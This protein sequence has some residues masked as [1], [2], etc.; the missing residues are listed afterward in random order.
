MA[1]QEGRG[2]QDQHDLW[3]GNY[4]ILRLLLLLNYQ[5]KIVIFADL[6]LGD[7]QNVCARKR[8]FVD[9]G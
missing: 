2:I 5:S 7:N 3:S 9:V 6:F 4:S 8:V 1:E